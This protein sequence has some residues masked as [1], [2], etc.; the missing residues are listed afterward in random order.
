MGI[1][2]FHFSLPLGPGFCGRV[3]CDMGVGY[4]GVCFRVS[5]VLFCASVPPCL[6]SF[7]DMD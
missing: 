4:P 7:L 2:A 1:K 6:R 3:Y 5:L